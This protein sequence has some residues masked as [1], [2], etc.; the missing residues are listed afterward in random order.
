MNWIDLVSPEQIQ[1]IKSESNESPVLIFKHSTTCSISAMAFHRLQRK[2]FGTKFYYL[3]L[4]AN[5]EVSNLVATTF[6]VE[7]ESPQVLI[8]DKGVAVY[9]RSHSDI[10][11][12]DIRE[13]LETATS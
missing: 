13:F 8:I 1:V 12:D 11:P 3:D 9:H 10:I 7:H 6:D 2:P 4:R 5:R